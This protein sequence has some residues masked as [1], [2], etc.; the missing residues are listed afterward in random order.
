MKKT[1]LLTF[2]MLAGSVSLAFAGGLRASAPVRVASAADGLLDPIW[3]PDGQQIAASGSNYTGIYVF[4]ADGTG[5]RCL[6]SERG[7]GYKMAWSADGSEIIGRVNVQD[8]V[9]VLHET[10]AWNA[11]TGKMRTIS[12]LR[13]TNSNPR[14][15]DK[16]ALLSQMTEDPA[17]I[18]STLPA[19]KEYS[20]RMVINPALSP[21]GSKIAFQ[22]VGKGLFVINVDG[23]DL[24][25]FGTGSRPAWMPDNKTLVYTIVRDNGNEYTGSTVMTVNIENNQ[26]DMLINS[27]E[28][29]PV[30]PAVSPDGK[31]LAFENAADGAIY[32]VN[33]K[34]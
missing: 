19:L 29:I 12:P 1:L 4:N 7:A 2:A 3:S 28:Y 23:S 30:S 26:K 27:S 32:M 33:L 21:D 9:R 5:G 6:T 25:S 14:T 16:T 11:Q 34:K 10:K 22:I 8:G 18:T 24:R 15:S 13:R 17:S 20:G 31:R